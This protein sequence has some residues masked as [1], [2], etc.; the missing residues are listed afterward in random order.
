MV[1]HKSTDSYSMIYTNN[2]SVVPAKNSGSDISWMAY[3]T[4]LL[5]SVLTTRSYTL[6]PITMSMVHR[7]LCALVKQKYDTYGPQNLQH[8][9]NPLMSLP[10]SQL[11]CIECYIRRDMLR[12]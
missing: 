1:I 6:P 5:H 7:I 4:G 10:P 9:L 8:P 12:V 3:A 11:E 2:Q